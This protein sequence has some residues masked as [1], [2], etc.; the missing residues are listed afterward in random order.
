MIVGLFFLGCKTTLIFVYINEKHIYNINVGNQRHKK[1]LQRSKNCIQINVS[2]LI[3]KKEKKALSS[4]LTMRK[5]NPHM[6]YQNNNN[7]KKK[8]IKPPRVRHISTFNH[9]CLAVIADSHVPFLPSV[10][11]GGA[12]WGLR[13]R[14]LP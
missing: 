13:A 10:A 2:A 5:T 3:E 14:V 4:E 12:R 1:S 11:R 6:K 8:S 7:K 9:F